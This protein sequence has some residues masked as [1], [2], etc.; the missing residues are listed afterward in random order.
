MKQLTC[1]M[2]GSTDLMKQDGVF[3][4]QTCGCKY[5]VEEAKKMMI[6]GTVDVQ[7]TVKVDNSAFVEKYLANA[8]RAKSKEDWDETEKYYNMVEQNDP[9]NIEAIFYSS[10]GKAKASLVDGDIYKRQ[11]VFK[12]LTNCVSIIDDNYDPQKAKENELAIKE[13]SG[14]ILMMR[15][16][17]FVFTEWKNGYGVVT[18]TNKHETITLF[19]VLEAQFVESLENIIKK[20]EKVYLYELIIKHCNS[21]INYGTL[22]DYAKNG[23]YSKKR[24]AEDRK[25]AL[26]QKIREQERQA[27]AERIAKYWEEHASEKAALETEDANLKAQI[28]RITAEIENV[29]GK[30]EIE[31]CQ[32]RRRA[33]QQEHDSLGM[34]KGKQKKELQTKIE[35]VYQ[36]IHQREDNRRKEQDEIRKTLTPLRTRRKEIEEEL[37]KDRP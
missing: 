23:W 12:V 6:Q 4:C 3:V 20:D 21:L 34:F 28:D 7:G 15:G 30:A 2:C 29:P 31:A 16:S 19:N 13:M 18:R 11:Q 10:F 5:S 32:E 8:R 36:E 37:K 1:E 35:E 33:L 14:D 22:T 17:N 9:T 25:R 27:K 26:D 24:N